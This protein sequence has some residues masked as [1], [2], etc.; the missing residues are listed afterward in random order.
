MACRA[1]PL[2][3]RPASGFAAVGRGRRLCATRFAR[4]PPEEEGTVFLSGSGC[5][6][7]LRSSLFAPDWSVAADVDSRAAGGHS[8]ESGMGCKPRFGESAAGPDRQDIVQPLLVA[9]AFSHAG[10][11]TSNLTANSSLESAADFRLRVCELPAHR[12]AVYGFR[13][14][15]RQPPSKCIGHRCTR[16]NTD[17]NLRFQSVARTL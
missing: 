8:V 17:K 14:G 5:G 2:S 7:S 6:G 13:T 16:I 4:R 1:G 12:K 3:D 9:R 11:G 15:A 10:L